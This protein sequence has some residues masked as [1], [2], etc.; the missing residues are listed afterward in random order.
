M[1]IQCPKC[2]EWTDVDLGVCQICGET[3]ENEQDK[4]SS[5]TKEDLQFLNWLQRDNQGWKGWQLI[6]GY[7]VSILLMIGMIWIGFNLDKLHIDSTPEIDEIDDE[8]RMQYE[9]EMKKQHEIEM[10][11]QRKKQIL[12]N[13]RI[14][15][16]FKELERQIEKQNGSQ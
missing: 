3:L 7:I 13:Q 11:V 15:E 16:Q 4:K 2:K 8:E 1:Q 9:L 14:E 6:I 10:E 5:L 12:E